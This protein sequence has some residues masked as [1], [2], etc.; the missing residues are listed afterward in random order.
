MKFV[1]VFSRAFSCNLPLSLKL[2]DGITPGDLLRANIAYA[3]PLLDINSKVSVEIPSPLVIY[4]GRSTSELHLGI[5]EEV[6]ISMSTAYVSLVEPAA[7]LLLSDELPTDANLRLFRFF[8]L[9]S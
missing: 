5:S 4:V 6:A 7:L 1:I 9:F 8:S 2:L 3:R